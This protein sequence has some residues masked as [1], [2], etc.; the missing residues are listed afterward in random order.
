MSRIARPPGSR[1]RTSNSTSQPPRPSYLHPVIPEGEGGRS[2][3]SATGAGAERGGRGPRTRR[4]G[5]GARTRRG[6]RGART[7]RRR[8]RDARGRMQVRRA[9]IEVTAHPGRCARLIRGRCP[10]DTGIRNVPAARAEAR[11]PL[12]TGRGPRPSRYHPPDRADAA[13]ASPR[14]GPPRPDLSARR[15]ARTPDAV[16]I[17]AL[18]RPPAPAD[19]RRRT[20]LRTD[21]NPVGDPVSSPR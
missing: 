13:S 5:R 9:T 20:V 17:R 11:V 19:S 14:L 10:W 4:C 2:Y 12:P 21:G 18:P 7:A 15:D 3:R 16:A 1:T 8:D 6:G